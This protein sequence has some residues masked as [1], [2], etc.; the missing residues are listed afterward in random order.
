MKIRAAMGQTKT[1]EPVVLLYE[2][3]EDDKVVLKAYPS[4]DGR[5]VRIVLPEFVSFKQPYLNCDQH[6]IDFQRTHGN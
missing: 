4:P 3:P 5:T 1:G 6:Y 2:G